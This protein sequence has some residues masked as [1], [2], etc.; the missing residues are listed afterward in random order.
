MTIEPVVE[1]RF[2][3]F[4]LIVH[5]TGADGKETYTERRGPAAFLEEPTPEILNQEIQTFWDFHKDKYPGA[6]PR[7]EIKEQSAETWI[8]D[9]FSHWTFRLGQT[10]EEL[11]RSFGDFVLRTECHNERV[12]GTGAEVCLMGAEDRWRW[13]GDGRKDTPAP[14]NCEHCQK[15]GITRIDH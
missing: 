7:F 9:W 4:R 6:V 1:R 13:R 15:L 8:Q 11:L 5:F 14:C 12:R 3:S 2:K 10:D